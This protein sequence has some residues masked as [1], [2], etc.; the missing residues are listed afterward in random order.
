MALTTPGVLLPEDICIYNSNSAHDFNI[1]DEDNLA[2]N[3]SF[4]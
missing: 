3:W 1:A 4:S 2:L